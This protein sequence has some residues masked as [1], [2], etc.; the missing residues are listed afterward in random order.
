M[1][2]P[3]HDTV[4]VEHRDARV[5]DLTVDEAAAVG[6]QH[7]GDVVSDEIDDGRP[8]CVTLCHLRSSAQHAV[9]V[10]GPPR[11][12]RLLPAPPQGDLRDH[13]ADHD[14]QDH[15]LDVVRVVNGELVIGLGEEEV[16]PGATR[17]GCE[18]AGDPVAGRR[19]GHDPQH[20][21]EHR[22]RAG[23]AVAHCRHDGTRRQW[24]QQGHRPHRQAPPRGLCSRASGLVHAHAPVTTLLPVWPM[25]G[26]PLGLPAES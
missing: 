3:G 5:A 20:E 19:S 17:P 10:T 24:E 15:G 18:D 14:Q 16:E 22:G 23:D 13:Q 21:N 7:L 9:E 4:V 26:R 6:A 25:T 2:A 8:G 1:A 11:G 12:L